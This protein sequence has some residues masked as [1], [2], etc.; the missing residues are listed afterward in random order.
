MTPALPMSVPKAP[1]C[2][3]RGPARPAASVPSVSSNPAATDLAQTTRAPW[4]PRGLGRG[5]ACFRVRLLLVTLLWLVLV[6]ASLAWNLHLAEHNR[7]QLARQ[8]A[9]TMFNHLVLSRRWNAQHGGVYVPRSAA[10][11]S[12]PYLHPAGRDLP[13]GDGRWLTK[14]NPAY[15]TR[16]LSELAQQT[17]GAQFRITSLQPI[18]PANAPLPWEAAALRAFASGTPEV[19]TLDRDGSSWRYRYMAPLFT[20]P[21]CLDCHGD[22]G[23]RVGDV[24]G[25]ISVTLPDIPPLPLAGLFGTHLVIALAGAGSIL[26]LGRLL[27]RAYEDLRRQ[28][29]IDALTSIPN[30]RYFTEQLMAELHRGRRTRL[31]LSLIICDIDHFKAYNDHFGH[32]AGDQCLQAVAAVLQANQQRASDFCARYGGEEFVVVLPNTTLRTAARMAERLRAAIADL[33]MHHPDA[34]AGIVTISAGV[35]TDST[36]DLHHETLI[37]QADE[38]LYRAKEQG[39]NRIA[40]HP[41]QPPGAL[42]TAAHPAPADGLP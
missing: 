4:S 29:I 24:R 21:A 7:E 38:A 14:V 2:P 31:P 32:Q 11:P 8:A 28:A 23:Y 3:S 18:R 40:C 13:R 1:G 12:N 9:R 36:G 42:L 6:G 20:E 17:S 19:G 39:R 27:V 16:Q 41:A 15:M 10:T 34:P 22:Q 33:G 30:R 35:A 37:R 25:G 5:C 26:L